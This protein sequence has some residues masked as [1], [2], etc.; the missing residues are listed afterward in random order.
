M[1]PSGVMWTS[2][3]DS[4]SSSGSLHPSSTI[5][6]HGIRNWCLS[7]LIECSTRM[8]IFSMRRKSSTAIY[9]WI[10]Q[11]TAY[12]VGRCRSLNWHLASLIIGDMNSTAGTTISYGFMFAG[13][14]ALIVHTILYHGKSSSL[15]SIKGIGRSRSPIID[16]PRLDFALQVNPFWNNTVPVWRIWKKTFMQNWCLNIRTPPTGGKNPSF[17]RLLYPSMYHLGIICCS[18]FRLLSARFIFITS[19]WYLP[20]CSSVQSPFS[21]LLFFALTHHLGAILLTIVLVLPT[22]IITAMTNMA[23]SE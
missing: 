6:T 17:S 4:W 12:T 18:P 8:V 16:A 19:I 21:I 14:S 2:F 13:V 5:R 1:S 20:T 3:L 22:S 9:V 23:W 15:R 10:K 11:L 7:F